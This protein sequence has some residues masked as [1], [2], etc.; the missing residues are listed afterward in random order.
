MR[1]ALLVVHWASRIPGLGRCGAR[2]MSAR[3]GFSMRRDQVTCAACR[4]LFEK[5]VTP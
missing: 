4:A 2:G 3:V 5:G 1:L